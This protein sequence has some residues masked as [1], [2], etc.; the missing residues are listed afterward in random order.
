MTKKRKPRKCKVRG[1]NNGPH[2]QFQVCPAIH[3]I[4]ETETNDRHT[5]PRLHTGIRN[6]IYVSLRMGQSPR[7][8]LSPF[9]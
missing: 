6:P 5:A 8:P 9:C 2:C 3:T 4:Q 7:S 1:T